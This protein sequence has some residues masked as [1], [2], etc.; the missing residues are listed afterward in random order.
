M[1][2]SNEKKVTKEIEVLVLSDTPIE[3]HN[4]VVQ[5]TAA[6]ISAA[7]RSQLVAVVCTHVETQRPATILC[8]M[9]TTK[10][11]PSTAQYVPIAMLFTEGNAQWVHYQPPAAAQS[12]DA[13]NPLDV[14]IEDTVEETS[15]KS[16]SKK[17]S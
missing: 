17:A 4:D 14:F 2:K 3:E 13:T 9:H 12:V 16:E 5:A 1:S 6:L 7:R 15:D 8:A 10:E 11:N